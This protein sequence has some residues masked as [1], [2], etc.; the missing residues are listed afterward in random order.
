MVTSGSDVRFSDQGV[1]I[2][3]SGADLALMAEV[4]YGFV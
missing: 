4:D 1:Q 3:F 2:V